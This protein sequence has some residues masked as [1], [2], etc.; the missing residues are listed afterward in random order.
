MAWN[1]D[2]E[3]C[4]HVNGYSF[5]AEKLQILCEAV[6]ESI[7]VTNETSEQTF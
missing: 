2:T 3:A 6:T 7:E 4:S 5:E 1:N